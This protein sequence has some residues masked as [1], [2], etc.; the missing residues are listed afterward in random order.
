VEEIIVDGMHI[1]RELEFKKEPKDVT[2]LQF[3]DTT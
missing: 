1:A 2:E 3:H